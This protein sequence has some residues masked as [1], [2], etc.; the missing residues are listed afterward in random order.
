MFEWKKRTRVPSV[1]GCWLGAT[2]RNAL[3]PQTSTPN[4]PPFLF[5]T[6]SPAWSSTSVQSYR[7]LWVRQSLLDS[8]AGAG[9]NSPLL[10]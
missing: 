2:E 10:P 1:L 6:F 4:P 3:T 9:A 7:L 5:T 8:W